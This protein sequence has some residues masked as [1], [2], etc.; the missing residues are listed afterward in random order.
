MA[1]FNFAAGKQSKRPAAFG[2]VVTPNIYEPN[3]T[4]TKLG[5]MNWEDTS[6]SEAKGKGDEININF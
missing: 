2:G 6:G 5:I 3:Q 4:H 1:A